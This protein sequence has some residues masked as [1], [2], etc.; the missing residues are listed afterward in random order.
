MTGAESRSASS[1]IMNMVVGIAWREFKENSV[2]NWL[3]NDKKLMEF[4]ANLISSWQL[5]SKRVQE[6]ERLEERLLRQAMLQQEWSAR[7]G[8]MME[9]DTSETGHSYQHQEDAI[10]LEGMKMMTLWTSTDWEVV[11]GI[12]H[13]NMDIIM[14]D[15]GVTLVDSMEVDT[16]EA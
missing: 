11:E 7:R 13:R 12:E 6:C 15:L 5:E 2:K 4:T 3:V 9:I 16:E 10:I 14:E 1:D 8:M